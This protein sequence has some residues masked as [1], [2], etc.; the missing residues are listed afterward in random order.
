MVESWKPFPTQ[1]FEDFYEVSSFGRFRSKTRLIK[2]KGNSKRMLLGR[3]IK[4]N[5]VS[6]G[7]RK[8]R[9]FVDGKFHSELAHRV[10]AKTFIKNTGNLPHVNHL[11][12][13]KHDNRVCN[14]EWCSPSENERHKLLSKYFITPQWK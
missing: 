13:I 7:Y 6:K 10:I 3:I 4:T 12:G 11:N 1:Y 14:L 2:G 5:T 9:L 8:V